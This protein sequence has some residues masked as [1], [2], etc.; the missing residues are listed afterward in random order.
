M[1]HPD[2]RLLLEYVRC[3]TSQPHTTEIENH[4]F[5]CHECLQRARALSVIVDDFDYAWDS[6]SAEEHGRACR[7]WHK[8]QALQHVAERVPEIA[9]R[10]GQ[11]LS[12][13][14]GNAE[15][16][17]KLL[18]DAAAGIACLGMR[19]MGEAASVNGV[20][21]SRGIAGPTE[22]QDR[23]DE[24]SALLADGF[25]DEAFEVLNGASKI[26]AAAIVAAEREYTVPGWGRIGIV[27]D[28]ESRKVDVLFWPEA[29][30]RIPVLVLL[31]PADAPGDSLVGDLLHVES[32]DYL[33]AHFDNVPSGEVTIALGPPQGGASE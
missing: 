25:T 16:G 4:L 32:A 13:L 9:D 27:A 1:T 11:W 17:F 7:D 2:E 18:L 5:E 20:C 22:V 21:V 6:W 29:K 30:D 28:S 10:A 15:L 23:V 26:D 33:L 24:G 31:V 14:L 8:A 19:G 12:G 3:E